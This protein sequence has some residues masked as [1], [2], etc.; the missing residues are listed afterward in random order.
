[1]CFSP[2]PAEYR[3]LLQ[4]YGEGQSVCYP[5]FVNSDRIFTSGKFR[6]RRK[7]LRKTLTREES[8]IWKNIRSNRNKFR[9]QHSIGAY[10]A[11]FYSPELKLVIEI[12]G[13]QHKEKEAVLY[14]EDRT[15]YFNNLGIRVLRFWNSEV[16]TDLA[17]VINT[18]RKHTLPFSL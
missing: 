9:R 11:D 14:D 1:L 17:K 15:K 8:L 12:D 4:Q 7:E 13:N 16:N 6:D 3:H 18:I 5:F 10:V 2:H